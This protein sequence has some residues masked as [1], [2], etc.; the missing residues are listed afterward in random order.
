[1]ATDTLRPPPGFEADGWVHQLA[2]LPHLEDLSVCWREQVPLFSTASLPPLASI[3]RL[4]LTGMVFGNW[5]TPDLADIFPNLVDLDLLSLEVGPTYKTTLAG[6]PT[7]LRRLRLGSVL[8]VQN[9]PDE[10][11]CLLDDV[12]PRFKH[13][14]HL[15]LSQ[16]L[17]TPAA[18]L[19]YLRSLQSLRTLTFAEGA[20]ATDDLLLGIVDEPLRPPRLRRLT[21][22][23]VWCRRGPT[24]ESKGWQLPPD[25]ADVCE[26]PLWDSWAPPYR[27]PGCS[28]EGITAAV[29]AGRRNGVVVDG[30]AL[31]T[32][33]WDDDYEREKDVATKLWAERRA[34]HPEEEAEGK[35]EYEGDSEE[36]DLW[37]RQERALRRHELMDALVHGEQ[38]DEDIWDVQQRVLRRQELMEEEWPYDVHYMDPVDLFE[39]PVEEG[40]ED[41]GDGYDDAW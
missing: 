34:Q 27:L 1:M 6:A 5:G 30:T 10:P 32:V 4:A 29:E 9:H 11:E 16:F 23:H 26:P 7:G 35:E 37:D 33:G 40:D 24:V 28:D 39:E 20:L 38:E 25:M 18:L 36:G 21:L 19:P 3:T 12:L 2:Q 14:E 22:N 13:I 41:Q 17:F 31:E 8:V 15:T